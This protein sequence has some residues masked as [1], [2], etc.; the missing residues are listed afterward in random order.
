MRKYVSITPIVISV[1]M[2]SMVSILP[3]MAF[4]RLGRETVSAG[5]PQKT[6]LSVMEA[7]RYAVQVKSLSGA[8]LQLVDR[9]KG[10]GPE[11]GVAGAFD[12]RM[13]VFLDAGEY[14]V[15][16]KG[17]GDAGERVDIHADVFQA[18]ADRQA[19][20]PGTEPYETTL[21]DLESIDFWFFLPSTQMIHID[22]AGRSLQDMRLWLNGTWLTEHEP[23]RS[24]VETDSGRSMKRCR[25][26]IRCPAGTHKITV[27]GGEPLQW[28]YGGMES[29][30]YIRTGIESVTAAGSINRN[31][32]IFGDDTFLVD[33][34]ADF[35]RLDSLSP[36]TGLSVDDIF[37]DDDVRLD[38]SYTSRIRD[39]RTPSVERT[40]GN[41]DTRKIVRISGQSGA[42]YNLTWFRVNYSNPRLMYLD[43]TY[44]V[45]FF[46]GGNPRDQA[47][48]NAII[49]EENRQT[50]RQERILA[51]SRIDVESAATVYRRFNVSD[52]VSVFVW[53]KQAGKYTLHSRGTPCR[54]V[55]ESFYTRTP[56]DYVRP[57]PQAFPSTVDVNT[58]VYRLTV[59]PDKP[60][61]VEIAITPENE[62][63]G[64]HSVETGPRHVS[65]VVHMPALIFTNQKQYQF[66]TN[67]LNVKTGFFTGRATLDDTVTAPVFQPQSADE[68]AR[69]KQ[70]VPQIVDL[71]PGKQAVIDKKPGITGLVR[72]PVTEAGV[73]EIAVKSRFHTS[74]RLRSAMR[75]DLYGYRVPDTGN[76]SVLRQYLTTGDYFIDISASPVSAGPV[77]ITYEK[78]LN[79]HMGDIEPGDI[80]RTEIAGP[81]YAS[82]DIIVHESGDCLIASGTLNAPPMLRLEDADGWPLAVQTGTLSM[83]ELAAGRYRLTQIAS[84]YIHAGRIS[85]DCLTDPVR[86]AIPGLMDLTEPVQGFWQDRDP[87]SE[88]DRWT[89]QLQADTRLSVRLTPGMTGRITDAVSDDPIAEIPENTVWT[90]PVSAGEWDVIIEPVLPDNL[91]PYSIDITADPI[92]SGTRARIACPGNVDLRVGGTEPQ[93]SIISVDAPVDTRAVLT[94]PGA[95]IIAASDDIQGDWNPYM[96]LW[97]S[98]GDY[99][100]FVEPI[101]TGSPDVDVEL[102]I[103]HV[104]TMEWPEA[105]PLT[106]KPCHD[107]VLLPLDTG[108]QDSVTAVHA[109]S[110]GVSGIAG[111]PVNRETTVTDISLGRTHV[112][113]SGPKA[114]NACI[115]W[116][117]DRRYDAVVLEKIHV[118]VTREPARGESVSL[119]WT[120][121]K[122]ADVCVAAAAIEVESPGSYLLQTTGKTPLSF[123]TGAAKPFQT[124][125]QEKY[126]LFS[127]EGYLFAQMCSEKPEK[128][129]LN[130]LKLSRDNPRIEWRVDKKDAVW[131]DLDLDTGE[132]ALAI[133]STDAGHVA[134]GLDGRW[135]DQQEISHDRS[136]QYGTQFLVDGGGYKQIGFRL[137]PGNNTGIPYEP[138][139]T[140]ASD[141]ATL[142]VMLK[143][144]DPDKA[145]RMTAPAGTYHLQPGSM[146]IVQTPG[147]PHCF[148]GPG[149]FV[150]T[151]DSGDGHVKFFNPSDR[152]SGIAWS[153]TTGPVVL[154]DVIPAGED[155]VPPVF[156][157]PGLIQQYRFTL[158]VPEHIGIYIHSSSGFVQPVLLDAL[159]TELA[160]GLLINRYLEAGTYTLS[161][162]NPAERPPAD[163]Q[164]VFVL[165]TPESLTLFGMEE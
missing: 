28:A 25:F 111:I 144:F 104:R 159:D 154:P 66:F 64:W 93:F 46:H 10:P 155:P 4:S 29:P 2:L 140:A 126:T 117:V 113:F 58:Y 74:F 41:A 150:S 45:T 20:L 23:F 148:A 8:S 124:V 22:A 151:P 13:D 108:P 21:H 130:R 138:A 18:A 100:L 137:G 48:L 55:L 153:T 60:G 136:S 129:T 17:S 87:G 96:A 9:I 65:A 131:V 72:I 125:Y 30:L 143:F 27:Y 76:H 141:Q 51:S 24:H 69:R 68:P 62:T 88:G 50:P 132:N 3:G 119:N 37:S 33:S 49:I 109:S 118:P 59:E 152:V 147:K 157:G 133:V 82:A 81:Q 102:Y 142:S 73:Y 99:T 78:L 134:F 61:L 161:I 11:Y 110:T 35:F 31:I 44:D 97:L 94:G 121:Q 53:F 12:G 42:Q 86:S 85:F 54:F 163:V 5:G 165:K 6:T 107:A 1:L 38:E 34:G 63:P 67:T 32:S 47:E 83:T 115:V 89:F 91:K 70:T 16:V 128:W 19:P 52:P 36:G 123:Q 106:L 101:R 146:A 114:G 43:G 116:S 95:G 149:V 7:G 160:S 40:V 14:Q 103:P 26:L 79:L 57:L 56:R 122:L 77:T 105:G 158:P 84:P 139:E 92:V 112:F 156:L 15:L 75:T 135:I 98:P 71:V 80:C 164:P 90:G 127:T 120:T 145:V 162:R 39:M